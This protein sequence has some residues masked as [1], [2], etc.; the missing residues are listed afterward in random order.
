MNVKQCLKNGGIQGIL[1][2]SP[3]YADSRSK[4]IVFEQRRRV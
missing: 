1:Y 2:L 3:G 4:R